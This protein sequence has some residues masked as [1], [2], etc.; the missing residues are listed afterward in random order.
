MPQP[1]TDLS[2]PFS[3]EGKKQSETIPPLKKRGFDRDSGL[4]HCR[5]FLNGLLRQDTSVRI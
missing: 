1:P 5:T 2:F 3:K 4:Y